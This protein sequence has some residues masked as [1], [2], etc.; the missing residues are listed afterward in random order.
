MKATLSPWMKGAS[1]TSG[2]TVFRQLNGETIMSAKPGK[3]KTPPTPEALEIQDRFLDARDYAKDVQR[4]PELLAL[5]QEAASDAGKSVYVLARQD[6]YKP[7]RISAITFGEYNGEVG[8]MI[9]FKARDVIGIRKAIVTL[10]D[11][12]Q[13]TLIE[14]GLATQEYAGTTD[15]MYTTTERVPAGVTVNVLIEAYDYPGNVS[16]KTANKQIV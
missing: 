13:G 1:G 9:T 5:Y 2:Q 10:T 12:E 6:W 11:A 4:K 8:K 15:W 16:E 3:R 7:A 14:R